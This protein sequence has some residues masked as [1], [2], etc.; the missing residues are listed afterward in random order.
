VND[1]NVTPDRVWIRMELRLAGMFWLGL[2]VGGVIGW[3]L[4]HGAVT[5]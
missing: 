5:W 3:S 1:G 4:A 2:F